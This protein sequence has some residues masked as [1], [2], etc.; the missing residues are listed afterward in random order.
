MKSFLILKL[1]SKVSEIQMTI[2]RGTLIC[3]NGLV[4]KSGLEIK[5]LSRK[6]N[7]M[8]FKSYLKVLYIKISTSKGSLQK[9][10]GAAG[11][12]KGALGSRHPLISSPA[13][14]YKCAKELPIVEG[15]PVLP[16][17]LSDY[18]GEQPD[19]KQ[20]SYTLQSM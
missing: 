9:F 2:F 3:I 8:I 17:F 7:C 12:F 13:S 20:T 10:E 5:I 11:E 14:Y 15:L 18:T 6:P 19:W 4:L 1:S 16:Y